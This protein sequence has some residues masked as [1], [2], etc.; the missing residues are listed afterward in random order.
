L[1]LKTNFIYLL[2]GAVVRGGVVGF[3]VVVFALIGVACLA[4]GGGGG[5]V[6]WPITTKKIGN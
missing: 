4:A 3:L 5:V 6:T 1:L 2:G